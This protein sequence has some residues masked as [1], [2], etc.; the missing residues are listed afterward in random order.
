NGRRRRSCGADFRVDLLGQLEQVH[1]LLRGG[2]LGL[3]GLG[4]LLGCIDNGV[5]LRTAARRRDLR[6]EL[7]ARLRETALLFV[8]GRRTSTGL[9]DE[10]L[11]LARFGA[12]R[13]LGRTALV[14]LRRI[15]DVL[16][17]GVEEV[18]VLH[19]LRPRVA[20][21][22]REITLQVQNGLAHGFLLWLLGGELDRDRHVANAG[23]CTTGRRNERDGYVGTR[24]DFA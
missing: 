1:A 3:E 17:A 8:F 2:E 22:L 14:L 5:R 19:V 9:F 20:D 21:D 4:V 18:E 11:R 10:F 15:A 6:L 7:G 16:A 12:Q 13:L 23:R 24:R